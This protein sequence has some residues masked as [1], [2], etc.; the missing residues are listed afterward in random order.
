LRQH[1]DTIER[2]YAEIEK[3]TLNTAYLAPEQMSTAD[4][5]KLCREQAAIG[6]QHVIF[7]MPNIQEIKPLELFGREIIP[8]VAGL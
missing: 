6:I 3:T 8:V 5:I 7:N 2:D 4:V 1:C